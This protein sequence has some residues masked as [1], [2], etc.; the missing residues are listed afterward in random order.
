VGG[1]APITYQW[2]LDG[3]NLTGETS[4]TLTIAQAQARHMGTYTLV[5]QN[6]V[7]SR[8]SDAALLEVQ[9]IIFGLT[10][11]GTDFSLRV[12]TRTGRNYILERALT[13]SGT[14]GSPQW[15]VVSMLPGLG[16][17]LTFSQP[18]TNATSFYRVRVD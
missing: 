5:A 13:L 10:A 8:T 1:D 11:N 2:R 15:V 17:P 3:A 6:A 4:P 12:D 9:P 7:G 18:S 14:N 16:S